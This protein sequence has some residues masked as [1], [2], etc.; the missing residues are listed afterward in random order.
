MAGINRAV[1]YRQQPPFTT[2]DAQ[3]VIPSSGIKGRERGGSRPGI[4]KHSYTQ[5]GS[6]NPIRLLNSVT[7]TA[8]DGFTTWVDEFAGTALG[9]EWSTASWIGT[10]IG[11]LPDDTASVDFDDEGGIVRSALTAIDTAEAYSIEIYIEPY[12]GAHHGTYSLFA[13]MDNTTP[14]ATTGGVIAELTVTG[15]T[16]IYTG[17]LTVYAAGVPTVY[18]FTGATTGDARG[19]WFRMYVSSNDITCYWLGTTV[20]AA[21]TVS[22][23]VGSRVGFG[24]ETTVEGGITLV[25]T[26]RAQYYTTYEEQ[27]VRRTYLVASANGSVYRDGF[28]G[29]MTDIGGSVNL[30]GSYQL[31][32]AERGQSLYIADFD[33]PRVAGTDGARGTGNTKLDAASVSDWS[34]YSIDVNNDVVL[35]TSASGGG[36]TN[37]TYKISS[38]A[39]GE[40]TLT[41]SWCT[42]V[43]ATCTYSIQ[44]APKVYAPVANTLSIWTATAGQVPTGCRLCVRYRDRIVLAGDPDNPHLWYMSRLGDPLDFDYGADPDDLAKAIAGTVAEAGRIGE[45]MTAMIP[46]TDDYLIFGCTNSVWVLGGD[47]AYGGQINNLSQTIGIVDKQAWCRGPAGEIV[48][49]SRDGLYLIQ[50]GGQ[51][52]PVSISRE[53]LPEELLNVNPSIYT[54]SM[55]YDPILRGVHVYS[56]R[57]STD[58]TDH[59]YLDWETKSFWRWQ[60]PNTR[61]PTYAMYFPSDHAEETGVLLGCRDGYIRRYR[62]ANDTDE[63]TEVTSYVY[64]GPIGLSPNDYNEGVLQEL[65]GVLAKDS[66]QVTWSVHPANSAEEAADADALWSGTWSEGRNI[67]QHPRARGM[68]LVVK[69]E[70]AQNRRWAVESVLAKVV[71]GGKVRLT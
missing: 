48:F 11:L 66:G 32:S 42:G 19:G 24:M 38:V 5:L 10:S 58:S 14:V 71:E 27:P 45:P 26:F 39:S 56:T 63:G 52:Y 53:R 37:G 16:G 62:D 34:T 47:P 46:H 40:I 51:S 64:L 25:D 17:Q 8:N 59:W 29:T 15:A 50:A 6:G 54:V 44:R 3:N 9:G 21:T 23:A 69:L 12:E 57:A 30:T 28:I 49:L 20:L 68:A 41:T 31:Q 36:G 70:N 2:F 22:A 60:L 7:V 43:G 65:M 4:S 61:E 67:S 18:A 13:R 55:V 1:A 33:L 35:I